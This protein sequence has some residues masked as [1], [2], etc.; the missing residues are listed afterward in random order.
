MAA[1]TVFYRGALG[2]ITHIKEETLDA[3]TLGDLL[4]HIRG[5]YGKEAE[6]TARAMLITV[7]GRSILGLRVFHT[8][9]S[10]GDR[11]HFLPICAGG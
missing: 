10:P 2:E 1:V 3:K 4:S 5:A 8:A 6:K 9:L 7:N 11:V